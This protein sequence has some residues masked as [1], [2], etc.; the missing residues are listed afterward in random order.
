MR[1]SFYQKCRTKIKQF[2]YF[3]VQ[4]F[5]H[6]KDY[7]K[8]QSLIGGV[9]FIIYILIGMIYI[10]INLNGFINRKNYN[11][12]FYDK[13]IDK[14]HQIQFSNYSSIFSYG[15]ECD[16]ITDSEIFDYISLE[17]NYVIINKTDRIFLKTKY[18][19]S[20]ELCTKS[21]FFN[22]FNSSF[23]NNNLANYYCPTEKNYVMEGTYI[24]DI[25]RYFEFT[26]F[27]KYDD[28]LLYEKLTTLLH[29]NEC[30]FQIF[31]IDTTIDVNDYENPIKK[32]IRNDF[33]VL[34]PDEIVKMNIFFKIKTFNSFKNYLF[35]K[36]MKEYYISFSSNNLYSIK[37]GY[38]RINNHVK[39]YDILAKIYLRS[40]L[41]ETTI[42]RKYMKL[43]EFA[44]N[45]SS[46][47][48][49]ILLILYVIFS[50]INEFNANQTI[51]NYIFQ[52]D[53][54]NKSKINETIMLLRKKLC[55]FELL[56]DKNE[57]LKTNSIMKQK[58]IKKS[59]SNINISHFKNVKNKK[60]E[61]KKSISINSNLKILSDDLMSPCQLEL[62]H[63]NFRKLTFKQNEPNNSSKKSISSITNKLNYTKKKNKEKIYNSK[64]KRKKNDDFHYN[65]L[66]IIFYLICPCFSWKKLTIKNLL[67][68]KGEEKLYLQLDILSYIRRMQQLELLNYILLEPNERIILDFL[69]KPSISL[70][71]QV[72]IQQK[73]YLQYQS[74]IPYYEIDDFTNYYKN[75]LKKKNK[76]NIEKRLLNISTI[77]LNNI[78]KEQI[79]KSTLKNE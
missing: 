3:G 36:S 11:I 61:H 9:S 12:I 42:E 68:K 1:K 27:L 50:T 33:L 49:T 72:D 54:D 46:L 24:N 75:L 19:I 59:N 66:E 79:H 65:C 26:L 25:F 15:V 45:M 55:S 43:T 73:I 32:S 29:N 18:P 39:E 57:E 56:I 22:Q 23:D 21:D 69:S 51:M 62:L 74:Y 7:K 4:F 17:L 30:K 35:D 53:G 48:S 58:I 14:T 8:Y 52:F 6:Y 2:D 38:D 13:Q 70:T 31:Y 40:A 41:D 64:K 60:S 16:D 20:S 34:K 67:I 28:Q 77:H 44:A 76:N 5:F 63:K 78:I 71:N 10:S 37:K 47:L